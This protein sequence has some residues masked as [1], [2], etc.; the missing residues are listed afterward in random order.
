MSIA[1]Q[2][3]VEAL[4]KRIKYLEDAVLAADTYAQGAY[5]VVEELKRR[6][7]ELEMTAARK[8]GPKPKDRNG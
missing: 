5:G 6:F 1:L 2:A 4:E 8:T 3:K 7:E